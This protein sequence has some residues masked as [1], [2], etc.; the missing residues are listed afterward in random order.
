MPTV[1]E[2]GKLQ[3]AFLITIALLDCIP[4]GI[5]LFPDG[6]KLTVTYV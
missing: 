4:K 3:G 1:D 2:E 5:L 6:K